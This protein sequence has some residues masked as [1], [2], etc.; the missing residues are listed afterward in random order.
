MVLALPFLPEA[1]RKRDV[2]PVQNFE[3]HFEPMGLPALA[4]QVV[5]G[6]WL[7]HAK[8]PD[9]TLWLDFS[10]PISTLIFAKLAL[11]LIT[12]G[13]ALHAR[14]VLIPRLSPD[15][16]PG[17]AW[18]IVGVTLV[19]VLFVLVGVGLRTGGF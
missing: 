6:F 19:S 17:L 13:L 14:L 10:T 2:A 7:A 15:T 4:I 16:L 9:W 12:V 8:L 11:L 5:T 18:H 1:L 3:Q